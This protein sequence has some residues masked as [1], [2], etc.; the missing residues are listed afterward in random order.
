MKRIVTVLA[1]LAAAS[2][3]SL[4]GVGWYEEGYYEDDFYEHQHWRG[5]YRDVYVD[6]YRSPSYEVYIPYGA[7]IADDPALS[8]C[9]LRDR[10]QMA[11]R[12]LP[13]KDRVRRRLSSA[14]R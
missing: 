5:G 8:R 13:R 9:Q 10:E 3:P 1:L 4:A 6:P 14:Q 2:S 7:Y 12:P 11:P